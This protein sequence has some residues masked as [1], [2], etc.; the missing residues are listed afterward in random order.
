MQKWNRLAA[1]VLLLGSFALGAAG[2]LRDVPVISTESTAE[3]S[4]PAE[5]TEQPQILRGTIRD[6][7]MYTLTVETD[8]GTTYTFS[9][10]GVV[11]TAGNTGILLGNPVTVEY[12]GDLSSGEFTVLSITVTD[13]ESTTET[14]PDAAAG[15][16]EQILAGMTLEEKVAQMI[17]AR[18]PEE[19]AV[20][21]VSRYNPG[22][23]LLFARDFT[24]KSKAEVIA[25]IAEYQAAAKIPLFIGVD[26]EGGTVNR[27]SR[28]PALR[29]VPFWSPQALYA[30]GGFD[31]IRSDT[32]EKCD[33]LQSL[34][35]NL[36]FAPVCDVSRNPEDFIY[37]RSFGRSAAETAEYVRT[38]VQTMTE[39]GMGSVLK[40]FPGYGN[41]TDTHSGVAYDG[42]PYETFENE[43]FLPFQAGIAAGADMVLV[44]HNVVACMDGEKPASLSE[45]VHNILRE[46]LGFDGV[47]ITDD[48]SMEGV[49]AFA[50]DTDIG[51]QA[52]LAGNDLLC[53][54]D[55][56][57]RIAEILDAVERGT[58]SESRIDDSVLRILNLKIALGIL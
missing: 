5:I 55:F 49:Q 41:N 51:V 46:T 31:L 16:T 13:G 39:A 56:E 40:H 25:A 3:T 4:A 32:A 29:A 6:A 47:I 44:A 58:I 2:C 50:S 35:I 9:T 15:R 14:E 53:C 52:V 22:G 48:L 18:C 1:L 34:G 8:N 37:D 38:V 42:R 20:E 24:G 27:V 26:E 23:Y 33:L 12:T 45:T 17:L 43:D 7:A 57:A 36:N 10:D 19:G 28:N 54:T 21:T 30:A 11:L